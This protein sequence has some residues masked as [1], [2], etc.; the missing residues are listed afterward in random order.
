MERCEVG[1]SSFRPY[2]LAPRLCGKP[3]LR[4]LAYLFAF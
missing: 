2:Q 3:Q 1:L 4:K